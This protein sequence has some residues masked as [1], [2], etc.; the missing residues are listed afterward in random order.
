MCVFTIYVH[1]CIRCLG[2]MICQLL[3]SN[4]KLNID[5][6]RPSCFTFYTTTLTKLAYF[7]EE[8]LLHKSKDPA[9]NSGSVSPTLEVCMTSML[10]LLML[11]KLRSRMSGL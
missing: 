9:L 3:T 6:A 11:M 10:V 7:F 8:P 2:P 1:Q 4:Q 5:S